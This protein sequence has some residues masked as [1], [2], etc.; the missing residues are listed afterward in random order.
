MTSDRRCVILFDMKRQLLSVSLAGLLA[1]PLFAPP[2][3]AEPVIESV[4]VN[5]EV[6]Y[7]READRI[8]VD[9][10]EGKPGDLVVIEGRGFGPDATKN[11][12]Q[13]TI[14]RA[15]PLKED[16]QFHRHRIDVL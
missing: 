10:L 4:S 2:V 5:G 16:I 3:F 6:R 15:A 12:S 13:V 8:T 9:K 1:V 14:N 11:F 7:R